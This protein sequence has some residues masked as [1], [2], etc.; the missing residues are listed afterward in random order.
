MPWIL[1]WWLAV[2][3]IGLIALPLTMFTLRHLPDRG[4]AASRPLGLLLVSYVAWLAGYRA[5]AAVSIGVGLVV[6]AAL[7]AFFARGLWASQLRFLKERL[8]Y[9]LLVEAF[10]VVMLL[11]AAYYKAETGAIAETEKPADFTMLH[12]LMTAKH[13]PPHDAWLSGPTISYYYFGYYILALLARLTGTS[14]GVTFN[15]GLALIWALTA[16]MGFGLGYALTRRRRYG[17]LLAFAVTMMG[18][19]DYWFRAANVY[20]GGDLNHKYFGMTANPQMKKGLPGMVEYMF[21]PASHNWAYFQASR[22]IDANDTRLI[23]EFPAF[24]FYLGDLHPHV[25]SL[26]FFLLTLAISLSLLK[27]PLP[28]LGALGSR[29]PWQVAQLVVLGVT[30]GSLGF[31][32]SWDLPTVMIMLA[33][34]LALRELWISG[35]LSVRWFLTF[36]SVG[37]PLAALAVLP[38]LPFY[39]ALQTQL[40]GIGVVSSRTDLYYW[41]I[42][43]GPFLVVLIPALV[44]RARVGKDGPAAAPNGVGP[45][46]LK[47]GAAVSSERARTKKIKKPQ[48]QAE[49][50]GATPPPGT[51]ERPHCVLCDATPSGGPVCGACGGEIVDPGAT[52]PLPDA[53]VRGALSWLGPRL[54]SRRGLWG[55]GLLGFVGAVIVIDVFG[56]VDPA[57]TVLSVVLA[58]F[59]LI[60]LGTRDGSRELAFASLLAAFGFAI[61]LA[62]EWV[63]FKDLFAMFP[64]LVRM[65]TMFK[66][67]I[68]A[69]L[70][71]AAASVALLDWLLRTAWPVWKPPAR[72]IWGAFAV[73]VAWAGL[74]FPFVT[75]RTRLA[76]PDPQNLNDLDGTTFFRQTSPDDA[77]AVDWLRANAKWNGTRPP[78][79]LESWGASFT[80][81]G[82]IAT[83]TGFPTLLGWGPH[84]EQWRGGAEV[85][86][87]GGIDAQ[88]TVRRR[89][90]DGGRLYD[91]VD[92]DEARR[93]LRRYSVDYV[94]IGR[95]ER[96]KFAVAGLQ[97]W[98]LLGRRV[99]GPAGSVEIYEVRS[100]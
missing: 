76:N 100:P 28:G 47:P 78:V 23:N 34:S 32:N 29:R 83:Y 7:S 1:Y 35:R 37:I 79:V 88:D 46:P 99:Y 33:L 51:L 3:L 93:L 66:F 45:A 30:Y 55:P 87:R 10:F 17:L 52:A 72:V 26:P 61:T 21:D 6:V 42:L 95:L 77:A 70:L 44:L 69:W 60:A 48:K 53:R 82:R 4:Y 9:V 92:L 94:Y 73:F 13:M 57:V 14:A 18:N 41:P 49:R 67:Y 8:G 75:F 31:L 39:R 62:C 2:S 16:L 71:L 36:A 89:Y 91:S 12:A 38:Y 11:F 97:K 81:Y 20:S 90:E 96:E 86:I 24:S 22:I 64:H 5:E 63:Y 80:A 58:A 54:A 65:N 19:L 84:E 50:R 98:P 43:V 74:A 68:H 56:Q 25:M 59:A 15:L 27:A 85:P 40:K